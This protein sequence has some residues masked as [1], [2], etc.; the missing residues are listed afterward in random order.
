VTSSS[1]WAP[2][3]AFDQF[4]VSKPLGQGGMGHVYLGHDTSL[5]RAV[6]LKVIG[7]AE[8]RSDARERFLVEARAIARLQHPNVVAIYR[9]GEVEGRPY[10]AYELVAGASLDRLPK[11]LH[12]ANVVRIAV[13]VARGLEAVHRAGILHRDLKPGNIMLSDTGAVKLLDFGL[14]KLAGDDGAAAEGPLGGFDGH[15]SEAAGDKRGLTRPGVLMGTPAYLAPELWRGEPASPRSDVYALGLVLYE[16][17]TGS[18]PHAS[19]SQEELAATRRPLPSVRSRRG[20]VPESLADI[21]DRCVRTEAAERFP[22]AIELCHELESVEAVFLPLSKDVDA[23]S[24]DGDSLLIAASLSR[25]TSGEREFAETLYTRLF[26]SYPALR[27]MFPSEMTDQRAKL[28]HALRLAADGLRQPERL[29]PVLEDLGRRHSS[30]G[31]SFQDLEALGD[32]LVTTLREHEREVWSEDL[33]R[34]WRRAYSFVSAA[35]RRG[36]SQ[37]DATQVT[38]VGVLAAVEPAYP[39]PRPAAAA[40]AATPAPFVPP[41]TRYADADGVSLAYQV[42]GDG[43]VDIVLLLGW[44]SHIELSWEH[45]TLAGFLRRLASFSRLIV[46]DKR[47]TGM[48]D[49]GVEVATLEQRVDDVRVVMDAAGSS[50]AVVIGVSDAGALGALYAALH[51]ERVR[52]LAMIGASPRMLVDE[53]YP[54]GHPPEFLDAC[55]A[56]I[57]ARWGEPLFIEQ[58]APSQKDDEGFRR[59]LGSYMR[60]SAGPGAAIAMLRAAA[61]HDVRDVLP[62]IRVP[63]LVLHR[64]DDALAPFAGGQHIAERIPGARFVALPGADHLPWV[65][66][67]A[68]ILDAIEAHV[69]R[70]PRDPPPL[71]SVVATVIVVKPLDDGPGIRALRERFSAA[72]AAAAGRALDVEGGALA[73]AFDGAVRAL[74]VAFAMLEQAAQLALPVRVGMQV[75]ECGLDGG[76]EALL[77]ATRLASEGT[78]GHVAAGRTAKELLSGVSRSF[79]ARTGVDGRVFYEL[80]PR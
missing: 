19:L 79:T 47:G 14:A 43:P 63:T 28:T 13:G 38:G 50:S 66:D 48:S 69:R 36:Y 23:I 70:L 67:S 56:E 8:P 74:E 51:P 6:A 59:W 7:Q 4:T 32:V 37:A 22:S 77:R 15:A 78:P 42:I 18:L 29:T 3:T 44:L 1:S 5:D 57:R 24:L 34:A 45:P 80:A 76:G 30:Y 11:P 41:R 27:P 17:L 25:V 33:E 35:M 46:F 62:S 12:W 68:R 16:L 2:P 40:R 53:D 9:I 10:I 58:Q 71:S 61:T 49:R 54:H 55:A 65:G 21:I 52:G 72:A 20:D 73:A 31:V 39:A 75:G 60:M 64:E 26:S